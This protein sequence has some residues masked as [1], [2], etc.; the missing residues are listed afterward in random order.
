MGTVHKQPH[1]S[2][3]SFQEWVT[4][5]YTPLAKASAAMAKFLGL[6]QR[7]TLVVQMVTWSSHQTNT[8]VSF[9]QLLNK[10]ALR[11]TPYLAEEDNQLLWYNQSIQC[12]HYCCFSCLS[13]CQS[14]KTRNK[15]NN[16][17]VTQDV[18]S[19]KDQHAIK[20]NCPRASQL[21]QRFL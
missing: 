17:S 16:R 9:L 8:A 10:S 11:R 7:G 1:I 2:L 6:A 20:H 21:M 3:W 4:Q 5:H 18:D 13:P 19:C 12:P 15:Q 14:L